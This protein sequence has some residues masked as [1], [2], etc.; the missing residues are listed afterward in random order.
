MFPSRTPKRKKTL[1]ERP[2]SAP[3]SHLE[4][5]DRFLHPQLA[6]K[7]D[8]AGERKAQSKNIC[9]NRAKI[10]DEKL[11]TDES[12]TAVRE[13]QCKFDANDFF[14]ARFQLEALMSQL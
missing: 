13:K 6:R 2:K 4:R 3:K 10:N 5:Q 1:Q 7:P 12:N 11:K 14:T 8:L 9:C